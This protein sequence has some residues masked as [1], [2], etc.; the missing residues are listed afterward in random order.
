MFFVFMIKFLDRLFKKK[1]PIIIER[2]GLHSFVENKLENSEIK[3][4]A[5]GFLE[6]LDEILDEMSKTCNELENAE[7]HNKNIPPRAITIMEGNRKAYLH[8]TRYF[9]D[10]IKKLFAGI[11]ESNNSENIISKINNMKEILEEYTKATQKSYFVLQEFFANESSQVASKIKQINSLSTEL[12]KKLKSSDT[13]KF[14]EISSLL[15]KIKNLD[16]KNKELN[17]EKKNLEKNL[18]EE[19]KKIKKLNEKTSEIK[20]SDDFKKLSETQEKLDEAKEK[21]KQLS[22]EIAYKISP[23]S[24]AL[25]KF[26]K[27]S[28]DENSVNLLI[29]EPFNAIKNI[30]TDKLVDLFSNLRKNIENKNL[31]L[32]EKVINKYI[33]IISEFNKKFIEELKNKIKTLNSRIKELSS[34]INKNHIWKNIEDLNSRIEKIEKSAAQ[35]KRE[36]LICD[37]NINKIKTEDISTK[38]KEILKSMDIEVKD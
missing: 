37:E 9:M 4:F 30:E 34:E 36:I 23:L 31:G 11:S 27:I 24:R 3:S 35:I 29:S 20:N 15:E 7:L 21:K 25:R 13:H 5:Q 33:S 1:E 19:N 38:I 8:K 32:K 18:D 28:L 26:A 6:Q 14:Q 2:K 17:Q 12:E 22:D 16:E 10:N